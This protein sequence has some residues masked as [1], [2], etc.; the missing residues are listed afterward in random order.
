ML[1]SHAPSRAVVPR[2]L[3]LVDLSAARWRAASEVVGLVLILAIGAMARL[4]DLGEDSLWLDEA[5]SVFVAKQ[6][7]GRMLEI[8]TQHDTPP[9]L[10]YMLLH[11]WLTIWPGDVAYSVRL[12][13]AILGVASVFV[14]YLCGRELGGVRIGLIAALLMA[15]SPFRVWYSQ[16]GRMY[17]LLAMLCGLSAYFLFRGLLDGRMSAW[18]GF[19]LTTALALYTQVS[20]TFFVLGEVVAV[21]VFFA[22]GG[23]RAV[24]Q[25][26]QP[27]GRLGGTSAATGGEETEPGTP[28]S[29]YVVRSWLVAQVAVGL[30]WLP[31]LPFL[32]RQGE[33]YQSFW[34]PPPTL[35]TLKNLTFD[36]TSI[37]LPHW[38]MPMG[39]EIV[40]ALGLALALLGARGLPRPAF[41][42]ALATFLVP[43]A[44]MFLVSQAKPVFLSRA[45][46]Y[47]SMPYLLLIASGI[48]S[49]KRR[50]IG[51]A[52]LGLLVMLNLVSLYR[53]YDVIQK[54]QWDQA[55]SYVTTHA[56]PGELV[57]FVATD[58]QIAFDYYAAK[59]PKPL[60]RRGLPV[61]VLTVGPLEPRMEE[62][63]LA[64]MDEL[65]AGRP[66][67]WLVQSHAAFA[68]P[69]ELARRHADQ[70]YR[71]VD[72]RELQGIKLFRYDAAQSRLDA[73]QQTPAQ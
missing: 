17:A 8:I 4:H 5:F 11:V 64:R 62:A 66:S 29:R 57:L 73:S 49:F 35:T 50:W 63:D 69:T 22:L 37:Y 10:Y 46:I 21:L 9:P 60:E 52:L 51:S 26:R 25:G 12:L 54:E 56:A 39:M 2:R 53:I 14:T 31:W 27:G 13:S 7:L 48:T 23:R 68:D 15:V 47:V 36:L 32:L 33:T 19:A 18:M 3:S 70:R 72:S 44:A 67:F 42:F 34:I 16:E 30:L 24:A 71:L 61:D 6:P 1:G 28:A 58:T 55:A 65:V 41:G 20:A 38:R 45:L 43:I 40:V 59:D